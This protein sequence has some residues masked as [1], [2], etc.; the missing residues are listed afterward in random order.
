MY[1]RY[2]GLRK[3]WLNKSPKSTLSEDSSES[4]MQ[5]GANTVEICTAPP[6]PYLSQLTQFC[7]KKCLS[8]ICKV[9]R[10]FV[11]MLT[12][13]DKYSLRNRDKLRQP[14]EKQLSQEQN[15]FLNFFL[16]F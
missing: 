11:S 2:F 15:N 3:T 6:L 8:V 1:L 5:G 9:L 14:I 12:K 7:S 10:M 13:D 16:H 4:D